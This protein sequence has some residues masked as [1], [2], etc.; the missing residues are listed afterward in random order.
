MERCFEMTEELRPI[1]IYIAD[2]ESEDLALIDLQRHLIDFN[3]R[4]GR[5]WSLTLPKRGR[6]D[7]AVVGKARD[8]NHLMYQIFIDKILA[9]CPK[10]LTVESIRQKLVDLGEKPSTAKMISPDYLALITKVLNPQTKRHRGS[11][12]SLI[13][14]GQE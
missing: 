7:S 5:K 8:G 12:I 3:R 14:W 1:R 11:S 6:I 13:Q 10:P 4:F 9:E 2:D